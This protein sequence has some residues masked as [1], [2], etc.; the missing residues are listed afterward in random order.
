[1]KQEIENGKIK[2]I[3]I[4]NPTKQ[5]VAFLKKDYD[6]CPSIL[7]EYI[8]SIKRPKLEE[9]K[10]YL[11][12]VIHFPVFDRKL[13]KTHSTELDIIL[14]E[15]TLI[16][17][18]NG[19]L[20]ELK[21][22]LEK[23]SSNKFT[24]DYYMKNNAAELILKVLDKLIDTRMPMLDHLDDNIN[25]I[26]EE[27]FNGNERKMVSEIAIVKHDMISFRKI[28]KPQKMV[29]E[30][31]ARNL[32]KI[33]A[34]NCSRLSAEVIG[35]NIKIWNTLEN[36]KEMIEALEQTNES[37]LSYKL[38]NTMKILTAFSVIVLPLSLMA[39]VF[40]MNITNGM[41]FQESPVGFLIVIVLMAITT[42][43]SFLFFKYNKWI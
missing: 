28:V 5:N 2:W 35:S 37:L 36:H 31:L 42:F 39:N 20:P 26:E 25:N 43:I 22:I 21:K 38:N 12:V 41:P 4:T 30:S 19:L 18:Q 15:N 11:F 9:Y 13:R 17:S 1:M 34:H 7:N 3:N 14:F 6:I 27:I 33:T 24:R 32:Y 23:C 40:G 16:T 29:L 10:N 8:P